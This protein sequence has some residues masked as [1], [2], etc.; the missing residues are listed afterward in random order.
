MAKSRNLFV[1]GQQFETLEFRDTILVV[2]SMKIMSRLR[3]RKYFE[4]I[5]KH[6]KKCTNQEGVKLK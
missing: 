4:T 1:K 6:C 5:E 2:N 3:L